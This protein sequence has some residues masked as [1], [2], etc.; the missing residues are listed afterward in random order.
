MASM[1]WNDPLLSKFN[2]SSDEQAKITAIITAVDSAV[3]TY[4]KRNL[5]ENTYDRICPVLSNGDV[6]LKAYPVSRLIRVQHERVEVLTIRATAAIAVVDTASAALFL[7][8]LSGGSLVG[9]TL[10]YSSYPT[11]TQLATAISL[12]SGFTATVAANYGD[13]PSTDL[14]SGIHSELNASSVHLPLF[15]GGGDFQVD[16]ISGILHLGFQSY[17]KIKVKWIGGYSTYPDDLKNVIADM[18]GAVA[19]GRHGSLI[20]ES[21]GGE[22]SYSISPISTNNIPVTNKGILDAYKDRSL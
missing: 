16:N 15:V 14:V 21:F 22:Y 7:Q 13:H 10:A 17:D 18:V 11:L 8:S 4:C 6:H 5:A 19:S 20:S 3:D 1:S 12:V 9:T 2:F